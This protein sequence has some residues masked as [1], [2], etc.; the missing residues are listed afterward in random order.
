MPPG[1]RRLSRTNR[2]QNECSNS[3]NSPVTPAIEPPILPK[4][5]PFPNISVESDALFDFLMFFFAVVSMILQFLNMYKAVWWLPQSYTQNTNFYLIDPNL[6]IFITVIFLRRLYYHIACTLISK[7][8]SNK[9]EE[10]S[11]LTRGILFLFFFLIVGT[12]GAIVIGNQPK[13]SILYLSY[14]LVVYVILFGTQV[15]P[16]FETV[17]WC[18]KGRPPIHACSSNPLDV[19]RECEHLKSNFNDRIKQI[20]FTS[21]VNAYYGGFIPFSFA[22]PQLVFDR[23]WCLQHVVYIFWSTFVFSVTHMLSLR[24]WD[25]MHRSVLH[26]GMWE[27]V[28]PGRNLI[29]VTSEWKDDVLWPGGVLVK[30]EKSIWRAMGDSNSNE[31][32]DKSLNRY[33]KLCIAPSHLLFLILVLHSLMVLYQMIILI[34]THMWYKILAQAIMLF[35]NYYGMYKVFRDFLVSYSFYKPSEE[36]GEEK[37]TGNSTKCT[38]ANTFEPNP[39]RTRGFKGNESDKNTEAAKNSD[40]EP[41]EDR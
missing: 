11:K 15:R 30:H 4:H 8:L 14:P 2:S 34:K 9:Y 38:N 40:D 17:S 20:C 19:R 23:N 37:D 13:T 25:V 26:L 10:L 33:Y 29:L 1:P 32:G 18:S 21:I 36:S 31:P 6:V 35:F 39:N 16:F 41:T 3:K 24:Y 12:S 7:A 27:K 22:Q 28:E 5:F